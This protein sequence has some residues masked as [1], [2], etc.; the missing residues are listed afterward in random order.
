MTRAEQ[1]QLTRERLLD[2]TL[3]VVRSRGLHGAT[4]EEITEV[5]GYTRGA[6]YAHFGSKEEA[7]LE[8]LEQ[9]ADEQI[10][11]FRAAVTTAPSD[12]A[13]VRVLASLMAK[14]SSDRASGVEYAELAATICR[15]DDLRGRARELQR[16]VDLVLGECVESI[17]ARRGQRPRLPREELGAIVGAILGGLASRTRLEAQLDGD[18]VFADALEL[19]VGA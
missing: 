4:I 2:A 5:A 19:V 14:P 15:S 12:E 3:G 1:Q 11:A 9:H 7:V 8:V 10:D 16:K 13:A 17:C 18:R 6:F